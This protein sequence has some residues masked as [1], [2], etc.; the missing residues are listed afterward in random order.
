MNWRRILPGAL[1]LLPAMTGGHQRALLPYGLRPGRH[2]VAVRALGPGAAPLWYPAACGRP[3]PAAASPCL[4]APSD[5]GRFPLVVLAWPGGAPTAADTAVA[6]YLASHG[7]VVASGEPARTDLAGLP[8]VDTARTATA[9]LRGG[10]ML[11][12]AE[13]GGWRLSVATPPGRS[14]HVRTSA[15]VTSAFLAAALHE[16]PASLPV[17]A[18]RLAAAGLGTRLARPGTGRGP[19]G[20]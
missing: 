15:A 20:R 1:V 4:A 11:L 5:S 2:D 3:A 6:E 18:R 12:V 9:R 14:D 17:L 16:R 8:F 13:A 7:F 19:G 10:G